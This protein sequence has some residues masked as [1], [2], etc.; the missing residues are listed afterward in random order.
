MQEKTLKQNKNDSMQPLAIPDEDRAVVHYSASSSKLGETPSQYSGSTH[1]SGSYRWLFKRVD[2]DLVGPLQRTPRGNNH[3]PE[4]V[5][6]KKR[7]IGISSY[8]IS[9]LFSVKL[10][11]RLQLL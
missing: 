7:S 10:H 6:L 4:S 2:M 11:T 5:P 1:V 3:Y 8:P 9:V